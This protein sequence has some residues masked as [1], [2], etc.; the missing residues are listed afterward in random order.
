MQF[1]DDGVFWIEGVELVKGNDLGTFGETG[2][3]GFEFGLDG[4]V[5]SDRVFAG[6]IDEV[7]QDAGAFDVTQEVVAQ[8]DAHV[9]AFDETG[10]IGEDGAVTGGFADDAEVRDEGCER[11][12]G[13]FGSR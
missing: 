13:D 2:A 4:F 12:I 3:V 11:V 1:S 10:D 8:S 9:C 6:E 5:G 7:Q